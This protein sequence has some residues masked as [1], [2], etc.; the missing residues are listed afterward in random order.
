MKPGDIS[1]PVQARSTDLRLPDIRKNKKVPAVIYG[2]GLK[3]GLSCMTDTGTLLKYGTHHYENTIFKLDSADSSLSGKM[4]LF[5]EITRHPVTR[6]PLHV[7]FYSV[8]MKKPVRVP[9][10]FR[11]EG[12][13]A[14]I[15]DG[16]TVQPVMREIMVE[17]LP[18]NIPDA[19]IIDVSSLKISDSLHVKEVN[20]PEGVKPVSHE[21]LTIVTCIY[22]KEEVI[23]QVA[24]PEAAA[25]GAAEPEVIAKGKPKEGEA[26][27][28][29]AAPAAAAKK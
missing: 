1:L 10:E 22:I 2:A 18:T 8:D 28:G 21:N 26:V 14:G 16:G 24:A 13:A 19:I 29:A 27:A 5:K 3:N 9:V 25:A 4:V 12:K 6:N 23:T 15:A 20:F 7:D 11:F 17:C